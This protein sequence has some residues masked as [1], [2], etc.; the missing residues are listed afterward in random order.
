MKMQ[1]KNTDRAECLLFYGSRAV[2][3]HQQGFQE[4]GMEDDLSAES[5]ATDLSWLCETQIKPILPP[6][7]VMRREKAKSVKRGKFNAD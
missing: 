2:S 6:W 4:R 5:N 3:R 7:Q 1:T